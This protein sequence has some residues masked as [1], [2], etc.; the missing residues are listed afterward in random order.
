M[1]LVSQLQPDLVL[2]DINMTVLSGDMLSMLLRSSKDTSHIRL[3][4]HSSNDEYSL[5]ESVSACD[6]H[7]YICK[8]EIAN[9]RKK[10]D[11]YLS[12]PCSEDERITLYWHALAGKYITPSKKKSNNPL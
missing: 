9:L 11:Q 12:S 7:G 10:I 4:F 5:R 2:I 1:N 6:V 8:G 3:V